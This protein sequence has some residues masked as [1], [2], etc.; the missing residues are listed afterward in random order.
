MSAETSRPLYRLAREL[1][2]RRDAATGASRA[3]AENDLTAALDAVE[4][5]LDARLAAL[6][7]PSP[8]ARF[9]HWSKAT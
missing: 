7:L 4:E 2:A 5:D 9:P 3:A 8:A 1:L 6:P